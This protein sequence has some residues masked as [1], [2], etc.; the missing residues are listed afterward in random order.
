GTVERIGLRSTRIRTDQKSYVT[1]PNKQMVDTILDN[2]SLRTQRKVVLTL[3]ISSSTS[4]GMVNHLINSIDHILLKRND[5]IQ[6]YSVVLADIT[7][8]IFLIQVEYFTGAIP[9]DIYN[10]VR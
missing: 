7:K 5:Y 3:E 8:N 9:V 6:T 4:Y 2:L 1:V 10:D